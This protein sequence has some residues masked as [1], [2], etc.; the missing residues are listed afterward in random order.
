MECNDSFD[1]RPG[2]VPAECVYAFTCRRWLSLSTGSSWTQPPP[3]PMQRNLARRIVT[4]TRC[5]S[6]QPNRARLLSSSARVAAPT[7][8][9]AFTEEEVMLREAVR[10]F[11]KEEVEPKVRE[12]DENEMMDP[13]VIQGLFDQGLMGIETSSEHGGSEAS[14]TSAV[15]AIEEL[16]RIDPSVSVLCDVHNTLV[17]TIFR[18]Y[19]TEEQKNKFLPLL[20]ESKVGSFCLSEPA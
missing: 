5:T 3:A 6:F 8:L 12:M 15:I 16:A 10:R 19:G 1:C 2:P 4:R 11:A 14:F 7:S 9:N 18:K 17:N 20:A 13:S